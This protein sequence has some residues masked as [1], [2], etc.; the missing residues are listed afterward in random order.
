MEERPFAMFCVKE[1]SSPPKEGF[2]LNIN[3]SSPSNSLVLD[4]TVSTNSFHL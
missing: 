1:K 4:I 3:F 2:A